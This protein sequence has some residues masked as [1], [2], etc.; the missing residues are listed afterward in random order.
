[1][2]WNVEDKTVWRT[3]EG[4][5]YFLIPDDAELPVGDFLIRTVTGKHRKTDEE[6]LRTFEISEEQATMW[7]KQQFG[8][9]LDGLR[10]AAEGF[11][12][13]IN[14]ATEKLRNTP[15]DQGETKP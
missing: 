6:A 9:F 15:G 11:I 12:A 7:L 1:M 2:Q 5:R 8:N 3:D 14:L 4:T 13:K 10:G